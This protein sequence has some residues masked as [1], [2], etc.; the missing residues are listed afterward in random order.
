MLAVLWTQQRCSRV[1]ALADG[2]V[3]A[4]GPVAS[5]LLSDHPWVRSYF[6]SERGKGLAQ[7]AQAH[8]EIRG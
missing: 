4:E 1:A 2:K 7:V 3:V 8:A 5:M 6:G